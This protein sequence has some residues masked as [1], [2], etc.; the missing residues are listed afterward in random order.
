MDSSSNGLYAYPA[1]GSI[2]S[3]QRGRDPRLLEFSRLRA[4]QKA[5]RGYRYNK[6]QVFPRHLSQIVPA[7]FLRRVRVRVI[8]GLREMR[9]C[10]QRAS[11][12]VFTGQ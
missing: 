12:A 4:D 11:P 9:I 2:F 1:C 8:F 7:S 5:P 10:P 6:P 3:F